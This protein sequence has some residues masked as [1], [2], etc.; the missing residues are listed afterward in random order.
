MAKLSFVPVTFASSGSSLSNAIATP[1]MNLVG[2]ITSSAINSTAI[3][4]LASRSMNSTDSMAPLQSSTG[5]SFN[6][7]VNSSAYITFS[8]SENNYF[9]G[10]D[11]LKFAAGTLEVAGTPYTAVFLP[12]VP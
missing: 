10:V 5:G 2:I 1:S 11:Y 6:V 7:Q 12:R 4:F 9:Y 8:T 3:T